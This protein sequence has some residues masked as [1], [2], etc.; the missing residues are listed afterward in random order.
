LK[1]RYVFFEKRKLDFYRLAE[2]S[3]NKMPHQPVTEEKRK[4]ID[5]LLVKNLKMR[6][7]CRLLYDLA[8]RSQ[9]LTDLTFSSFVEV[10]GGGA[11]VTWEPRKQA[12]AGV[13]RKCFV[14]PG[15]MALVKEY[16]AD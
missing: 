9:D 13:V 8:A 10:P 16:Q 15:T 3:K 12:R 1:Y 7:A 6:L 2:G 5:R 4:E 14:T 11:N